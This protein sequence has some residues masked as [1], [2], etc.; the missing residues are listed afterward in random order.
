GLENLY[1]NAA[2]LGLSRR[3]IK[4]RLDEIVDFSELGQFI[5]AP[6]RTYSSGMRQRLGFAIAAHSDPDILLLDEVLSVGDSAFQ[7]K[8]VAKLGE[9]IGRARAIVVVSH[10]PKFLVERCSKALWLHEG[11]VAAYGDP[12]ET[13]NRYTEALASLES[14][15]RQLDA[16]AAR[17]RT[18]E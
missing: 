15:V 1:L 11:T 6:L 14:P 4:T 3:Q 12:R 9:L 2:F 7:A 17:L 18:A 8:C 5:D 10:Q 16:A 13:V